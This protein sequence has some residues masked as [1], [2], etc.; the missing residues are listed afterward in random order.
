[1]STLALPPG[2]GCAP[3]VGSRFFTAEERVLF[4]GRDREAKE[5]AGEWTSGRLTVLHGVAGIGKSSLLHAD[6]L[7]FLC[8]LGGDV[9]PVGHPGHRPHHPLAAVS[10]QNHFSL[11]VLSSWQPDASPHHIS[12]LSIGDFLRRRGGPGL[13]VAIDQAEML[14]RRSPAYERDR[15]RF[16]E[17]LT[18]ALQ[19]QES[20]RLLLCVREGF[21]P[22]ALSFGRRIGNVRTFGLGPLARSAAIE[23]VHGSA[24]VANWTLDP[25]VAELLVDEVRRDPRGES[26]GPVEPALLQ[27][28]CARLLPLP[29]IHPEQMAE[30]VDAALTDYLREELIEVAADRARQSKDV[31]DWFRRTILSSSAAIE[32]DDDTSLLCALEE[33]HLVRAHRPAADRPLVA[34]LHPRLT[35]PLRRLH[36]PHSVAEKPEQVLRASGKALCAG[37][38]ALARI[39]A[40]GLIG[41]IGP[42]QIAIR[43]RVESLLGDIA[44]KERRTETA[45]RHYRNAAEL[46]ETLQD[47]PGVAQLLTAVG[48]LLL[49]MAEAAPERAE[50]LRAAAV[51]ELRAAASRVPADPGPRAALGRALWQAG[52]PTAALAVLSGALDLDGDTPEVLQTR[53]KI[54]A[55]F[56]NPES[57][58]SALRDLGRVGRH[59]R[60][61]SEAARALALT[62]RSRM[63]AAARTLDAVLAESTD[64]GPALLHAA[65][66]E[67]LRGDQASAIKLAARAM[68]AKNPPLPDHQRSEAHLMR[69][70]P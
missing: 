63:D 6:V 52:D 15:R 68:Q 35:I 45:I 49:A 40:E 46:F 5:L 24:L 20:I 64:D 69:K 3:F 54:F 59:T 26:S 10:G 28:V 14:F 27:A 2:A 62:T 43:A 30:V 58:N 32:D 23:A 29:G 44:H 55:D 33:R 56:G 8:D 51:R 9:L 65:R 22:E 18:N 7:P 16:L 66:A 17:E 50:T 34:L 47:S 11:A 61:S 67:D 12:E 21:V 48:R 70:I 60:P 53:S 37:E 4:H 57:A 36:R 1:M 42:H 38:L 31:T 13:M 39:H 41:T 19:E 25:G